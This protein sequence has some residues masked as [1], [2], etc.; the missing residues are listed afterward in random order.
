L[1]GANLYDYVDPPRLADDFFTRG[2]VSK[3]F[4]LVAPRLTRDDPPLTVVLENGTPEGTLGRVSGIAP[5][6]KC[7]KLDRPPVSVVV[8]VPGKQDREVP[9]IHLWAHLMLS[10]GCDGPTGVGN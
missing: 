7:V 3:S 4:R 10:K 8:F 6:L 5:A 9:V 2:D 1:L